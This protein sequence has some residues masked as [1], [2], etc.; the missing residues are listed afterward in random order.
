MRSFVSNFDCITIESLIKSLE[1]KVS[2]IR[3]LMS[4]ERVGVPLRK[5]MFEKLVNSQSEAL[6]FDFSKIEEISTSVAEELG[7]LF[8]QQYIDTWQKDLQL[9]YVY[10]NLSVEVAQGL[11]QSFQNWRTDAPTSYPKN[12]VTFKKMQTGIF[13]EH[14]F[15]GEPIPDSLLTILNA[16]Y[17]L[18]EANSQT[19]ENIGIK[20]ASRKLNE[21]YKQYPWMV[22]KVQVTTAG[23]PRSW[24]YSYSTIVPVK[25][26][27]RSFT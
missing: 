19:L 2:D 7:P 23:D 13:C 15:I 26:I 14:H 25:E 22:R 8:F 5:R 16:I 10:V 9:Y 24:A 1:L 6:A 17:D 4:R 20:A 3:Y 12:F 27:E 11:Q 18:G 21:L